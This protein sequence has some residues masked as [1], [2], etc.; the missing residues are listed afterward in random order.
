MTNTVQRR[1][2]LRVEDELVDAIFRDRGL[3]VPLFAAGFVQFGV[4]RDGAHGP[5]CFDLN[6]RT[7]PGEC[8]VVRL[9][10]ERLLMSRR[11]RTTADVACSF[12]E[13]IG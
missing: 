12:L 7:R 11:I 5:I 8:P 13:L 3:V 4:P 2:D 1:V 10:H 9:D 6:R